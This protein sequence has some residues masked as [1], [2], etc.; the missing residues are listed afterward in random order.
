[1]EKPK[2]YKFKDTLA[3][4]LKDPNFKKAW[5]ASETEDRL[6]RSVLDARIRKN[7]SQKELADKIGTKQSAVSRFESG[8]TTNP[9]TKFLTALA[10]ALDLRLEIT[11]KAK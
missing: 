9:T 1:M 11:F 2:L 7:M 4:R 5:D 8:Y 10:T 3:K 6:I